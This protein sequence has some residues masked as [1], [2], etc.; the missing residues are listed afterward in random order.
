MTA[1]AATS[2]AKTADSLP[3]SINDPAA[4]M[5]EASTGVMVLAA[6][7]RAPHAA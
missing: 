4:A 7:E 3:D 1:Y 2:M 6:Q 5:L